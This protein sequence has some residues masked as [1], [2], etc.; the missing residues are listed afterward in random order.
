MFEAAKL[1]RK[2]SKSDFKQQEVD[3]RTELLAMQREL[4]ESGK[5]RIIVIITGVEGAGKG[6]VVNRLNE[7]MDARGIATYAFWQESDEER[8]HPRFW[9]FW[10]NLPGSGEIAIF[11][12]GWY[13]KLIEERVLGNWDDERLSA[14]FR[15]IA[16]IER[17]LSEDGALILKFWYHMSEK[18]QR[19]RLKDLSRDDRSRWKMLP[20]KKQFSQHYEDYER[21]AERL[22]RHTDYGFAPWYI[23]E[24]SDNRYR[25]LTTARTLL[26]V[27]RKHMA[28]RQ[29]N[30]QINSEDNPNAEPDAPL[31]AEAQTTILDR[32]DLS[33]GLDRDDYRKQLE[34]LQEEANELV[35]EAYNRKL[36]TVLVFEGWDA[37][38]KGGAI[39]RFTSAIDA[40]L[41]R[42]IS[43][44]APNDEEREHQY[45]W[46]F[47]RHVPAAGRVSIF[48]RSWYGR[49]LVERVE[50]FA[51]EHEWRRAYNEINDFEGQLIDN[52][53]LVLKFWLHIDKDEQLRRFKEREKIPYKAHKITEEDWRNREKWDEYK[54]AVNEMVVRTSTNLAPWIIVPGNDKKYAR[55]EVL[56]QIC[57]HLKAHLKTHK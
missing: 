6:E 29:N 45:L 33:K 25:D 41:Y 54:H 11:F 13:Q 46:R 14:E 20:K 47:W 27:A 28:L 42:Y 18:D 36:A 51:S 34:A 52:G 35:W 9:R 1:Q 16:G 23:V 26:T 7:W 44:A 55:V 56:R 31:S 3:L 49:V 4:K 37:G 57:S 24:A 21:I 19:K 2:V 5:S 40:R 17:M 30:C 12:G 8:D 15:R 32:I 48:D 39:R 38:G 50:G 10:R 43:I 53:A 22:I